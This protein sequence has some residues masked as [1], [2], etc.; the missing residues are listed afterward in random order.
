V[1][2][3]VARFK[4]GIFLVAIQA[5]LPV[6]PVSIAGSRHVMRKG[7]L[8]VRPGRVS[9]VVHPPIGTEGMSPGEAK[10]LAARVRGVVESEV[11]E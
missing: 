2:G 6:V 5:G 4:G 10:A 7:K 9:L 1:D 11:A 3:T 8:A